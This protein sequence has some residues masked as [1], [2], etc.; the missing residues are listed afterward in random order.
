MN[1]KI[2]DLQAEKAK[3]DKEIARLRYTRE[4]LENFVI[5]D[6]NS[7]ADIEKKYEELNEV[8]KKIDNLNKNS[9][10]TNRSIAS[11]EE[12]MDEFMSKQFNKPYE[13]DFG[14][15]Y[16]ELNE[17]VDKKSKNI[18]NNI[19][20]S[21]ESEIKKLEN[22]VFLKLI[23]PPFDSG[24]SRKTQNF[25]KE[26]QNF[27][28]R[29]I[30]K[31]ELNESTSSEIKSLIDSKKLILFKDEQS[32]KSRNR[33]NNSFDV[34]LLGGSNEFLIV[35]ITWVQQETFQETT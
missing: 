14:N 32:E 8:T 16:N 19:L 33:I 30:S 1:D 10:K 23:V 13:T 17:F 3:I 15:L 25:I 11:F 22:Y 4:E 35:L 6:K 29:K 9:L 27:Y 34:T 2:K 21:Q 24:E 28:I 18:L 20:N 12:K 31:I 7:M 5:Q 26:Y